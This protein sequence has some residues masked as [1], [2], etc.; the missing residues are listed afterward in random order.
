[1]IYIFYACFNNY[2]L[3]IGENEFFLKKYNKRIILLDDHS[4]KEEQLKG[5]KIAKKLG[6][7]FE[8][9]PKKG[10]QAGL[11]YVINKICDENDWVLCLQQDVYFRDQDIITKLEK[12]ISKVHDK[13]YK[14]GSLG[15]P[16][17]VPKSHYNCDI[18]DIKKLTWKQCWLGVMSLS[19]SST[20]KTGT[21]INS[22]YRV[23]SRV[24]FIQF[25]ERRFW[26]KVIFHRNFAPLTHPKFHEMI[27]SYKGL[28]SIDLPVWTA[29][30]ISANAWR[31]VIKP[32]PD[33]VFHLWFPDIAMQFMNKNWY[34]CLDTSHIIINNLI[35]KKKYGI[36]GS[37]E[38]GIKK[39]FRMEKYGDHLK[40]WYKK[41][42]F[43]YENPFPKHS[44]NTIINKGSILD[45]IIC[46]FS[47]K[48][49][50]RFKI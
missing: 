23:I 41:W 42:G 18:N 40:K 22:I 8:I 27:K 24:P 35:I 37:V 10:L 5:R 47:T 13:N 49:L 26:Q 50:K 16:N 28:V 39:S 31:K 29:I 44:K 32:D 45:L 12:T 20:Y 43:D 21:L 19:R 11:D 9:N 4:T 15:F 48:P 38:E 2:D 33:F 14:I 30:L 6:L 17:Y 7:R 34:V 25:I 3:L 36:E 1:M 46:N